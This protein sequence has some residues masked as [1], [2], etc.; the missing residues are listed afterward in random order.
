MTK[1]KTLKVMQ[2]LVLMADH[3]Q[4]SDNETLIPTEMKNYN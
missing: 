4:K 1:F 3:I 2:L